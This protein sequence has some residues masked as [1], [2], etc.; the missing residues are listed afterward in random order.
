MKERYQVISVDAEQAF[1]EWPAPRLAICNENI[2]L[3]QEQR[4]L[5]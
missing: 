3:S 2:T 4:D 5:L 1:D